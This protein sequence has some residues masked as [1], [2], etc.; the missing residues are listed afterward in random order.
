MLAT[1]TKIGATLR[2]GD[3]AQQLS[4]RR[5]N[6]NTIELLRTH[7]PAAPQI[8]VDID[9]KPIGCTVGSIDQHARCAHATAIARHIEHQYIARSCTRLDD[10]QLLLIG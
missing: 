5:E 4:A 9:T 7:A 2:Q 10:V 6:T 1:E 8:A 3:P